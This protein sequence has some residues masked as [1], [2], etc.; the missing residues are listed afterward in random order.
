MEDLDKTDEAVERTWINSMGRTT[1]KDNRV[2][3]QEDEDVKNI[4]AKEN[5]KVGTVKNVLEKTSKTAEIVEIWD[6]LQEDSEV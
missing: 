4:A 1:A 2:M 5:A 6:D 3:D